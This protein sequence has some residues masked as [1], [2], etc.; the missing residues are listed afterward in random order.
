LKEDTQGYGWESRAPQGRCVI[1]ARGGTGKVQV[2]VQ[3]L[4]PQVVYKAVLV[5]R[6]TD[7]SSGVCLGGVEVGPSRRCEVRFDINPDD[8]HGSGYVIEDFDTVAIIHQNGRIN[9]PLSGGNAIDGRW[10][11][12]LEMHGAHKKSP[13]HPEPIMRQTA[14]PL[15][16]SQTEPDAEEVMPFI[17]LASY[18]DLPGFNKTKEADT[19]SVAQDENPHRTFTEIIQRVSLELNELAEITGAPDEEN[20]PESEQMTEPDAE[21]EPEPEPVQ[22]AENAD[23]QTA[24]TGVSPFEGDTAAWKEITLKELA[25]LPVDL[26][27]YEQKAVVAAAYHLHGS[28]LLT[29][30]PKDAQG[31]YIIGVPGIYTPEESRGFKRLGFYTFRG[32]DGESGPGAEGYWLKEI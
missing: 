27:D 19:E 8:I 18:D 21:M 26:F 25:L 12:N 28:L 15:I 30:A 3:D 1:E 6:G 17:R 13:V 32:K 14:E 23:M 10:K 2:Y 22:E 4:K 5:K 31:T 29:G 7:K 11:V 20:I 24:S 9:I 16:E